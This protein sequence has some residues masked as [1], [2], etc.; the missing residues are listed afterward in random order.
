MENKSRK[1]ISLRT[2]KAIEL[3]KE[4]QDIRRRFCQLTEADQDFAGE[5][6]DLIDTCFS[7]IECM[8]ND[9]CT[10]LAQSFLKDL[11]DLISLPITDSLTSEEFSALL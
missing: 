8:D 10:I 9:I 5:Y 2:H 3:F 7:E 1:S 11:K 4:I 6:Q